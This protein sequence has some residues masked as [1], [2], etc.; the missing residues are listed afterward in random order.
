MATVAD[1]AAQM[2]RYAEHYAAKEQ[3]ARDAGETEAADVWK[4]HRINAERVLGRLLDQG[5]SLPSMNAA[6]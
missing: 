5:A 4:H 2:Q 1:R 3:A 6:R